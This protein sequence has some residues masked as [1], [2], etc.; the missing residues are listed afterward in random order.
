MGDSPWGIPHGVSPMGDLPWGIPHEGFP[1]GDSTWGIPHGGFPMGGPPMWESPHEG[2]LNGRVP[3]WGLERVA[4]VYFRVRE[5]G[6]CL[7][8]KELLPILCCC[9]GLS[10]GRQGTK[11][12]GEKANLG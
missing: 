2:I 12:S 8:K 7:F 9:L 6:P 11:D 1:M 10:Q 4:R 5:S 3:L